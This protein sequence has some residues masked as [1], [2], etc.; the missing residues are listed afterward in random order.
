MGKLW[1][2]FAEV[3][4]YCAS[5]EAF[6]DVLRSRR[7]SQDRTKGSSR[8]SLPALEAA[9]SILVPAKQSRFVDL[10]LLHTLSHPSKVIPASLHVIWDCIENLLSGQQGRAGMY[11]SES[12]MCAT[13][14]FYGTKRIG[15]LDVCHRLDSC[16]SQIYRAICQTFALARTLIYN[17]L[18]DIFSESNLIEII[19]WYW[20]EGVCGNTGLPI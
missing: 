6:W 5:A 4:Q 3:P 16:T 7:F 1:I 20:F 12:V 19:H 14:L 15:S 11:K 2:A 18:T 10:L 9:L 17:A 13:L 8:E